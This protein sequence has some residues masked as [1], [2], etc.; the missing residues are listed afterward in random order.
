[1]SRRILVFAGLALFGLGA[2]AVMVA[3]CDY[4]APDSVTDAGDRS[5]PAR[6]APP[7]L[8]AP[9]TA[10]ITPRADEEKA[11]ILASSITLIQRAPLQPGGDNFK[12]AI[13]KLNHY[14]LG[15]S[16]RE[17][18]LG[19]GA[20]AYLLTQVSPA[21]VKALESP[22][23]TI[24][25]ARHVEDCMMY[26]G[27]ATRV[28]Q[29]GDD[30][31]RVRRVFD[32][33]VRQVQLV[34]AGSL[35]SGR[36]IQAFAR[37]YDVLM[38]GMATET[39]GFWAERT[40][41]FMSLC[42][43]LGID[44]G[45]VTYSRRRT[46]ELQIPRY[47]TNLD[48]E[49]ALFGLRRAPKAPIIW[50]CAALIDDKAYLFDGRLGL[51]VPGPGGEGVATLDQAMEDPSILERMNLP[52]LAPYGT[53]RA[54][55]VGSPTKIG[56]ML[57]SSPGYFAPKMK[58]LQRELAGKDRTILYQD[59]AEQ[60]DRFVRALGDRL[61]S[62]TLWALPIEVDTQLFTNAR[63]VES[64]QASLFLFQ[65]H[66]PLVYARVKHLRGEFDEAIQDYVKLRFATNATWVDDKRRTIPADVQSGL[67]VYATYYLALAHLERGN[68]EQAELMLR[69]TLEILPEPAP[70]EPYYNMLR[71]GANA[72]LG[73]IYEARKEWR[74]AVGHYVQSDPTSQYVGN[75]LR[76]REV[77]WRDP[78]ADPPASL[79]PPPPPRSTP[80]YSPATKPATRAGAPR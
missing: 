34:P 15:T 51:E 28:A 72:N 19:S 44:T 65:R 38:R 48:L 4:S 45:L 41:L 8:D 35:G 54:S 60:R 40:W 39:E 36:L 76:A 46:L 10:S 73:R 9:D 74:R 50:L 11:A 70:S 30:L 66:F 13:Q 57:D 21:T 31:S 69:K 3:G 62:V 7:K 61:G 47:G 42:R 67:D 26:Y 1:L 2:S 49:A 12:H 58:L 59:P 22:N 53:S 79:P 63:F 25:D 64:I 29:T 56:I 77:V 16:P 55:L 33:V 14:F 32:W 43:Q 75:Q 27:I 18:E 24:R 6:S 23:W 20:R 80:S 37:P 71:W 17:F 52:G 5:G 68:L 78:M